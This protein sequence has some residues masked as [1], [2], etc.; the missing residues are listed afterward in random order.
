[1]CVFFCYFLLDF[2]VAVLCDNCVKIFLCSLWYP[3]LDFVF[4]T[5][6]L[7]VFYLQILDIRVLIFSLLFCD[8]FVRIFSF[9]F[10]DFQFWIFLFFC[11]IL[12]ASADEILPLLSAPWSV[13]CFHIGNVSVCSDEN[14]SCKLYK[15]ITQF[16]QINLI[17]CTNT[18]CLIIS[19]AFCS[20]QRI[21]FAVLNSDDH[22][23]PTYKLQYRCTL[24]R[25]AQKYWQII[26]LV[27]L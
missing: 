11:D 25:M 2:F 17:I 24:N 12:A 6:W 26:L 23:Y 19:I 1:M 4:A 18:F 5:L 20:E 13:D 8:I 9:V 7:C 14:T 10:L 15:Y 21:V 16:I 3:S 22:S 27:R